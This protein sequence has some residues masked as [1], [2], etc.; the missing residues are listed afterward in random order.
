MQNIR[1]QQIRPAIYTNFGRFD[2]AVELEFPETATDAWTGNIS[3]AQRL[4]KDISQDEIDAALKPAN[5]DT[6]FV[7]ADASAPTRC[8]DGRCLHGYT[9]DGATAQRA[10]G[11]QAPG[12]TPT[13]ALCHRVADWDSLNNNARPNL[14][15]DIAD[16]AAFIDN[17]GGHTDV[18][19]NQDKTGCGAIDRMPEILR[20]ITMPEAQ[21]QVRDLSHA[22]L[23][24]RYHRDE[25]DALIGRLV[26]L[27]GKAKR[28]FVYNPATDRY[29]YGMRSI[30]LLRKRDPQAVEML[31]GAHHE[32]ALIINLVDGT[33]FHRDQF[34]LNHNHRLQAFNYDFWRTLQQAH[35]VYP[36]DTTA[37]A[38][39]KARSDRL[40]SRYMS[41]CT[42]F[43]VGTAMV[44]TDG[45]L[46]L[47]VRAPK[48]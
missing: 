16:M 46:D 17:F 21:E 48:L 18:H 24:D 20:R 37:S 4:G 38:A 14:V 25:I 12:G 15:D 35:T 5:L 6:Y 40:R 8:I 29:D 28:Y 27:Q 3:V 26:S 13:A 9:G 30:E 31:D 2:R 41:M 7:N 44:L 22:L 43:A 45:S 36:D 32:V 1:G 39:E 34:S 11:P 33:T 10:L 19:A 42:L 47:V 23:G